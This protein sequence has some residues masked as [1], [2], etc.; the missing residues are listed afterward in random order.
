MKNIII[1]RLLTLE[2]VLH[3]NQFFF[4]THN[5]LTKFVNKIFDS[6]NTHLDYQPLTRNNNMGIIIKEQNKLFDKIEDS[7]EA[8]NKIVI[9]NPINNPVESFYEMSK[10]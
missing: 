1:E 2:A 7:N 3:G 8:I 9:K 4:R 10:N 6:D 5:R